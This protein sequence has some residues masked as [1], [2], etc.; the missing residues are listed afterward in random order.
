MKTT[1][2]TKRLILRNFTIAD[3]ESMFDS[4]CNSTKITKY[5]TWYP[6]KSVQET[7]NYIIHNLLPSVEKMDVLD[8]AI[9]MKENPASVIG[10]I[11]IQFLDNQYASVD[12]VLSEKHWN[13]SI[14]S[15]ALKGCIDFLTD[16]CSTEQLI[17]CS[18]IHNIGSQ[19]V[20]FKCGFAFSHEQAEKRKFDSN[21]QDTVLCNYYKLAL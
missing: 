4:Y 7:K 12:Y 10:S 17:A 20:L 8:L 6:H 3:A 21:T 2:K 11:N 16:F 5:L 1:I 15:E 19:T 14:M 18:D 9:T 13:Q